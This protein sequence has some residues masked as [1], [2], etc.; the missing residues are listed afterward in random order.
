VS[1]P[2]PIR[3]AVLASGHG[4][5]LRAIA[6]AVDAGTCAA[7]LAAVLSDRPSAPALEF[8][9]ARGVP[10]DALP[11]RKGD[12]RDAWNERLADAVARHQPDLVVFAG[13]MRVVGPA[14]LERFPGRI[15]NVHPALL[16]SFPGVDGAQLAIDARVR[17]SGC[18]VHVV[19]E[20]VD[21]GPILAQAAVPVLPDDDRDA[22][23]RRIQVQ[24]HR[25]LPRVV[26][27]VATGALDLGPPPRFMVDVTAEEV[28]AL[29]F[30][31]LPGDPT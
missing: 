1:T 25:L 6:H 30:P 16:P 9:R 3:I 10:A 20:G 29:T 14:L 24:E 13:F 15:I 26:H 8:A 7:Q 21:T 4:S 31:H 17:I 2:P 19:D 28:A 23:H 18:T 11:L 27:W 5:N 22:L 12:D